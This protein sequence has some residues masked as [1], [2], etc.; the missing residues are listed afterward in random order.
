M[1]QKLAAKRSADRLIEEQLYAEVAEEISSG[2]TRPGLWAKALAN[3]DDE[4]KAE[5]LYIKYRVQAKLDEARV[6]QAASINQPPLSDRTIKSEQQLREEATQKHLES[7]QRREGAK[8]SLF[9]MIIVGWPAIVVV[10]VI[11]WLVLK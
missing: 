11:M 6:V 3:A 8:K 10:V 5:G 2:S 7:R 9:S 4:K 1:F